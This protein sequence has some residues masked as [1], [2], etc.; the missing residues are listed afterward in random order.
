M[1]GEGRTFLKQSS[2]YL[3]GS[4]LIMA[5]S[6]ISFPIL[7][8]ILSVNDY[9]LLG[10]ISTTVS[11][12]MAITKLGFP[13]AIVRFYQEYK[14]KN[15]LN[16]FYSTF[17][18][19]SGAISISTCILFFIFGPL[20]FKYLDRNIIELLPLITILLFSNSIVIT[21]AC[22][23]RAEQRTKLYNLIMV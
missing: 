1:V 21:Y 14:S 18:F 23:L 10:L 8:R 12:F 19:G 6:F 20:I 2:H 7:T 4:I 13:V 15:Q 16:N 11:F 5:S 3:T 22:F 9:G 17:F